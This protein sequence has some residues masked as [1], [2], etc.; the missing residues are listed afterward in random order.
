[1]PGFEISRTRNDCAENT[2]IMYK[3][4]AEIIENALYNNYSETRNLIGQ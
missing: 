1:M 2:S 4:R 3:R